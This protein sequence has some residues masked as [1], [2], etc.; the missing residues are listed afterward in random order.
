MRHHHPRPARR[1]GFT[2]I[3]IMI[4]ILIIGIL[5]AIAIPNFISARESSRTKAC[6]DNLKQIDTAKL[7]CAIEN[8]LSTAST[9][10]FLLDGVTD[11]TPGPNGTYQLTQTSSSPGYIRS[12]PICPAGGTYATGSVAVAPTCST[13]TDPSATADYQ[14]GGKYYHGY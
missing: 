1:Q 5:L 8:K 14:A 11:T 12:I 7:Q 10:T 13:A 3:E 6:I 4:V 9:A 2:L